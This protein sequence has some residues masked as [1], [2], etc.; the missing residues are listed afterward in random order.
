MAIIMA[1][2]QPNLSAETARRQ[3]TLLH[4]RFYAAFFASLMFFYA[5][6][7]TST[8]M[9]VLALYSFWVPQIALNAVTEVRIRQPDTSMRK[10]VACS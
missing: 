6:R 3:V 8:T 10:R 5:F 1:A 9:C 2:R 7:E 4:A